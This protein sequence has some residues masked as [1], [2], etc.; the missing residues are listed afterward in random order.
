MR[1]SPAANR[2]GTGLSGTG[3]ARPSEANRLSLTCVVIAS[4]GVG[5]WARTGEIAAAPTE[6]GTN[7]DALRKFRRFMMVNSG[8]ELG[9]LIPVLI[10]GLIPGRYDVSGIPR[11]QPATCQVP[12]LL[13][14]CT[15]EA[16]ES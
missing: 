13:Y 1:S 15:N 12:S 3:T 7:A 2:E 11:N 14:Q 4:S 16:L 10:R 8:E 6:T 9:K 5:V